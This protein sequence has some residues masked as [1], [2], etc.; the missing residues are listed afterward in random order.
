MMGRRIAVA[1]AAALLCAVAGSVA[2][3]GTTI[4]RT[5]FCERVYVEL[6][7]SE[8]DAWIGWGYRERW[9]STSSESN[10]W[11]LFHARTGFRAYETNWH[12][13]G[14]RQVTVWDAEERVHHQVDGHRRREAPPWLWGKQDAEVPEAPW[15]Q[16]GISSAMWREKTFGP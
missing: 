13:P 15:V 12:D 10:S 3:H 9:K 7:P 8:Q 11:T 14:E 16:L 1:G 5:V 4:W 6:R 2:L